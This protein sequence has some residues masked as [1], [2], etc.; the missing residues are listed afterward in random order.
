MSSSENSRQT[1]SKYPKTVE[2]DR[3]T[4]LGQLNEFL[5]GLGYLG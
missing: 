4:T 1:T 5:S 2:T 3:E